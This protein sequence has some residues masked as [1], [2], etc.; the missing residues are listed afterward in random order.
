MWSFH[1]SVVRFSFRREISRVEWIDR[2]IILSRRHTRHH[3]VVGCPVL[4]RSTLRFA[5]ECALRRRTS[6]RACASSFS[7]S[8][9]R[10]ADR[11]NFKVA[12]TRRCKTFFFDSL[13][14]LFLR[15]SLILRRSSKTN[16]FPILLNTFIGIYVF[17]I[18]NISKYANKICE[19]WK[20]NMRIGMIHGRVKT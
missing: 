14:P 6:V 9:A 20:R 18:S 5:R 1:R 2:R 13:T 19:I 8:D 15:W 7:K 10:F 11:V 3:T 16:A 17:Y 4:T 12:N